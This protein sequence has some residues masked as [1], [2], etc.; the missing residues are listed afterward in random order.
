MGDRRGVVLLACGVVGS[1]LVVLALVLLL[2]G[3]APV[4]PPGFPS[5]PGVVLWLLAVAPLAHLVLGTATVAGGLLVGGHLGESTGSV[6]GI[7]GVGR[8]VAGHVRAAGRGAARPGRA[9]VG[10]PRLPTG[11]RAV[12]GR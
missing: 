2:A 6:R 11:Q 9:G 12:H 3:G 8:D 1:A 4:R 7:A 10:V 5:A